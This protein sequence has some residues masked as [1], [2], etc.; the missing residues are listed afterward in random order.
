MFQNNV[1][2]DISV[3]SSDPQFTQLTHQMPTLFF[4]EHVISGSHLDNLIY[5]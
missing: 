5:I 4:N 2:N 1:T 3:H